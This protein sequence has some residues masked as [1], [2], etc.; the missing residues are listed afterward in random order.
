MNRQHSA[1]PDTGSA[2]I[3][4]GDVEKLPDAGVTIAEEKKDA[5]RDAGAPGTL[6]A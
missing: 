4:A 6:F 2:G 1:K 5:G 3:P